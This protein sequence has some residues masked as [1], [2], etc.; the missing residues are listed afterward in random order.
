MVRSDRGDG[1]SVEPGAQPVSRRPATRLAP[2][3]GAWL[4][5]RC[6]R[7]IDLPYGADKRGRSH[8]AVLGAARRDGSRHPATGRLV[9]AVRRNPVRREPITMQRQELLRRVL[10]GALTALIV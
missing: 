9:G 6:G 3:G 4:A 7:G 10:L 2:P 5:A 1:G 8:A